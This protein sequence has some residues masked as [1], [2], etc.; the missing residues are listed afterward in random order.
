MPLH[1]VWE[2]RLE[3]GGPGRHLKDFRAAMERP[4]ARRGLAVRALFKLRFALGSVLRL[5]PPEVAA[6]PPNS[7]VHR[8]GADDRRR[9][10]DPPGSRWGPFRLV[11][12]LEDEA[13]GELINRTVHGF[14]FMGML[15]ASGGYRVHWAIYVL[16]VGALTRPYMALIDPFRRWLVYPRL[17]GGFEEAWRTA[18]HPRP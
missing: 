3:G 15:P 14:S 2:I 5:D 9:S 17:I 8:L 7:Y 10:L 4:G 12:A 1:D 11:Y 13:L 16:P 18:H 6:I